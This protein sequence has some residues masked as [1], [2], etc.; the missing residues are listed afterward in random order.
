MDQDKKRV[1]EIVEIL[2][3]GSFSRI[4]K[5]E[6]QNLKAMIPSEE[7]VDLSRELREILLSKKSGATF[8]RPYKCTRHQKNGNQNIFGGLC[9]WNMV[10]DNA[11]RRKKNSKRTQIT[12]A[13]RKTKNRVERFF[14]FY[15][16]VK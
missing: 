6:K 7:S 3:E 1:V 8:Q 4:I 11:K 14:Y 9:L 10:K 2:L 16:F 13:Q 15:S 5:N 12:V